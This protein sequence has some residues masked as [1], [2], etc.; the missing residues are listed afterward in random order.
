MKNLVTCGFLANK[1]GLNITLRKISRQAGEIKHRT[2]LILILKQGH[3][4]CTQ[5]S[6]A[7]ANLLGHP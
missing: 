6:Q 7:E 4:K 3:G 2:V 5:V 1:L